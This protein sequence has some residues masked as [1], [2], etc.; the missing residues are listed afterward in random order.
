MSKPLGRKFEQPARLA[1]SREATALV[2]ESAPTCRIA[3]T[4]RTF[5]I[6]ETLGLATPTPAIGKG[7]SRLQEDLAVPDL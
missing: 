6:E 4:K 7:E 2:G 1:S 5:L 3:V